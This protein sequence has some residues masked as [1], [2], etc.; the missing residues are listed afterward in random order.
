MRVPSP[1]RPPGSASL[2]QR[3][4]EPLRAHVVSEEATSRVEAL[5]ERRQ[6]LLT[7][8]SGGPNCP[9]PA[10]DHDRARAPT[11]A[12]TRPEARRRVWNPIASSPRTRCHRNHPVPMRRAPST[13]TEATARRR[14]GRSL[15]GDDRVVPAV[16]GLL[17]GRHGARRKP[18]STGSSRRA[19]GRH[20]RTTA[21]PFE[22]GDP[23]LGVRGEQEP[24]SRAS[25]RAEPVSRFTNCFPTRT[26]I[27]GLAAIRPAMATPRRAVVRHDSRTSPI[28]A[29]SRRR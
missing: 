3:R 10:L 21:A 2:R 1:R 28:S 24:S 22:R 8:P 9:V 6:E 14:R 23:F 25:R 4:A 12:I 18:S 27:A 20:P 5:P 17:R 19:P 26:A 29:P 11:P 16:L 7:Y 13:A 15:A